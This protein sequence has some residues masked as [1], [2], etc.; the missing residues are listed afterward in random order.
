MHI[1]SILLLAACVQ[2]AHVKNWVG[3]I[4]VNYDRT[5]HTPYY[6]ERSYGNS[7]TTTH[8][9]GQSFMSVI[10]FNGYDETWQ[11][12][13]SGTGHLVAE[14]TN[15]D[16]SPLSR[17]VR[18]EGSGPVLADPPLGK[19]GPEQFWIDSKQCVYGFYT[20][21]AINAVHSKDGAMVE[22]SDVHVE[23]IPLPHSGTLTGSRHFHLPNASNYHGG[24]QFHIPCLLVEWC[25]R[26]AGPGNA[27]VSWTFT[28]GAGVAPHATP[29]PKAAPTPKCPNA[30]TNTGST[31]DRLRADF[32]SALAANGH[33][34]PLG[35]IAASG[36]GAV[37]KITVRLDGYGR[38]LPSTKCIAEG[39]ANGSVPAGSQWG[40][41]KMLYGAVQQA[42]A[43]TRVTVRIVDVAT[44][45]IEHTGLGD[46]S[47]TGDL[48]IRQAATTALQK[49]GPL[50][51]A[52]AAIIAR[53]AR[54][55]MLRS[56]P[57][58]PDL[59]R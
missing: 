6:L 39:I 29:S 25:S 5:V 51:E 55:D 36:S 54:Q 56:R 53:S 16:G 41:Q 43:Q 24:D 7:A 18:L 8:Y 28:P 17:P 15:A 49:L 37:T 22:G 46:A 34:V 26:D 23:A 50:Y 59:A 47:G 32:A 30:N 3:T 21:A 20:S 1:A 2:F 27:T 57:Y 48:S 42:G 52:S 45:A 13:P 31:I 58:R 35:D 44:G 38:A 40:A 9:V 14:L 10:S 4:T 33:A 19:F 11:G 12:K